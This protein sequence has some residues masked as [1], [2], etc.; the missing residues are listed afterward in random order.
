MWLCRNLLNIK[1]TDKIAN[2]EVLQQ[3]ERRKMSS[4]YD[5]RKVE[6]M[7][8]TCIKER[9]FTTKSHRRKNTRKTNKRKK[10]N[11]N[12]VWIDRK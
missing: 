10:K 5:Q 2:R 11:W 1:C 6:N 8:R 7:D 3:A 4:S 12:V 9:E